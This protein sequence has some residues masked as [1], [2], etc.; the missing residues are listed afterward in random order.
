MRLL[1]EI[2]CHR[3]MLL[4]FLFGYMVVALHCPYTLW[5]KVTYSHVQSPRPGPLFLSCQA[6]LNLANLFVYA[7]S[8]HSK[9]KVPHARPGLLS[10]YTGVG[11]QWAAPACRSAVLSCCA[12]STPPANTLL[13]SSTMTRVREDQVV[14]SPLA[15]VLFK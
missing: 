5:P 6:T 4:L 10:S 7:V 14:D 13:P 15:L 11:L 3:V 1:G 8:N 12:P 9:S 2:V